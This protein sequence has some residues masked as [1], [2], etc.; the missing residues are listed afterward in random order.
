MEAGVLRYSLVPLDAAVLARAVVEEFRQEGADAGHEMTVVAT[1]P[2]PLVSGDR[3]A[4][5]RALWNLLDNAVKYSPQGT[6]VR[7]EVVPDRAGAAIHV[8]DRGVGIDAAE[9]PLIGQKFYRGSAAVR[10]GVKGT[11]IGLAMVRHIV[12]AHGGRFRFES[13]PGGGSTFSIE[14]GPAAADPPV[15][16]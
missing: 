16:P 7:V 2:L 11:G 4:L 1:E 13:A 9:Q 14:L 5:T 15:E 3:E 8:R 6:A 10:A 12:K